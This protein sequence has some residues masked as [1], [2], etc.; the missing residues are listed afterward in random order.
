MQPAQDLQ[1][2]RGSPRE[3][4]LQPT[5]LSRAHLRGLGRQPA[6]MSYKRIPLDDFKDAFSTTIG[7]SESR[8]QPHMSLKP[9]RFRR[10][11]NPELSSVALGGQ[12]VSAS[13][14][15]FAEAFHLLLVEVWSLPALQCASDH[16]P[17]L[18]Q[19]APSL[20]G[21]FGPKGALFSGWE[22]RRHNPNYDW[23]D[24]AL[25]MFWTS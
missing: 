16:N 18:Y 7:K 12:V 15:F 19:P 2:G 13:D 14:E 25:S 6:I 1:D 11:H 20:K 24:P 3:V 10:T 5:S 21:Q 17:Q 4:A 22:S 23:Y 8:Y 9:V